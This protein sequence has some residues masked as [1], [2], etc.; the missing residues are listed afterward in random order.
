VSGKASPPGGH[1]RFREF[2]GTTLAVRNPAAVLVML[3]TI[4]ILGF[5]AYRSVP[6]EASPEITIPV[7]AVNTVYSG[8]SPADIE[9]LITRVV[10]EELQG[11]GELKELTS[12]SVEGYS[13][14][15][16]EFDTRTDMEVALRKV[17]ERVDLAR[18]KLP[19]G[20]EEPSILEFNLSEFP[21]L[22]VNVSGEYGLVQLRDVAEDLRERLEQIPQILEVRLSGGLDREVRVEVDLDQLDAYGLSFADVADAI[23]DENINVPGGVLEVGSLDYAVR[24][25]GEFTEVQPLEDVV[26]TTLQDG[27][28]VYVRDVATVDFGFEDRSSYARLDGVPVVTLDVVQRS[29]EN[30]LETAAA[31][32]RTIDA[33]RPSLPASTVISITSDQSEFIEDMVATL[34][35]SIIS[36]LLLVLAV[37]LFFLGTRTALFVASAIPLSMLLSFIVL[38]MLGITMNMIVLFSLIL[39]LGMLVDNAVVIVENIYRFMEGGTGRVEATLRGTGEV[40]MPI[41]VSTLTTLGA[42]FPL[43]FW[44]GIVGEFMGFLPRTLIITLSSSLFVALVIIPVLCALFLRLDG[45]PKRPLR[46][47]AK[48]TALVVGA[49]T[50]LV[51]ALA[52]VLTAVLLALIA[53]GAVTL[54]RFVLVRVGHWF[55]HRGVPTA[56]RWYEGQLRWALDHRGIV[57]GAT[58][59]GFVLTLVGFSVLNAGVEFFPE[60]VPPSQVNVRVDVPSGTSVE[61]TNRVA[62]QLER[63]L[64]ALP[65]VAEAKSVVTTVGGSGMGG[66]FGGGGDAS[67]MVSFLAYEERRHDI[68]ATLAEMQARLGA[69]LAGADVRV[70]RQEMGPPT[71]LPVNLE[72][73]GDDPAVLRQLAR[74]AVATLQAAPVIDRLDGL[75]SD[76]DDAR[77]EMVIRVDRE[78]AAL[79]GVSTAQVGQAVRGAIQGIEAAKFRD[80]N[81]E[82]DIVVRLAERYRRDLES[83]RDLYVIADGGSRIP[84]VAVADWELEPGFGSIRRKD[85]DR[86]ATVSSDVRAGENSNAVLAEVQSTLAPFVERLPQGYTM[87]YTGQQEEQSD[88]QEFLVGAFLGAVFLILFLL[89][90]QFNSVVKPL[91]IMASVVLSIIGVLL[92]LLVFRMPFVI[93]M[94]GVGIISLAGVVVNNAIVLIDYIDLLQERDGLSRREAVIRGGAVRFRPVV[95]TAVTTVLG[96]VPLAIGLNIDFSGLLT[97]LQPNLFWGGEQ[98]AWWGP[99]AI[100]VI[101]GLTFSTVLTLMV[102]P[103][104]Y[105]LTDDIALWLRRTYT[106]ADGDDAEREEAPRREAEEGAREREL[107]GAA[108]RRRTSLE[109]G[110]QEA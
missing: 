60:S 66:M 106:H 24:T 79:Y 108:Y 103:V 61:F 41:I 110:P 47:A 35:N 27:S 17:R 54:N 72:I 21:I 57:M 77:S 15:V 39:A 18:P 83:L 55:Q 46:P 30:I 31:V 59:A 7:V 16:A 10:E 2:R 90:A 109:S 29:G 42:F 5:L 1:G 33:V 62:V 51:I 98:A 8:A 78:R 4:I 93:I 73:I 102:V 84:L 20:A 3:A 107:A 13:S 67:I 26:V 76:M 80:G 23:R 45:E 94:T 89:V 14:I 49:L 37:L 101:A 71:G 38:Q 56:V 9:T 86:V 12:T 91:I 52:N 100:T 40:A 70:D 87:R 88:A 97:A 81:E 63:E 25:A 43:L 32:R 69:D 64:A 85:M 75:D 68:F 44:P 34:E 96:L 74:E 50:F 22:Q 6:K 36:G 104:M 65:G 53:V 58:G 19:S 82:Y 92:G 95:L 105:S 28:P 11:I 99:M 48:R